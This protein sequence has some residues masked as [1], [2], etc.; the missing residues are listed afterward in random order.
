MAIQEIKTRISLDGESAYRAALKSIDQNMRILA[1]DTK[2]VA[3][4]FDKQKASMKNYN[5]LNAALSKQIQQQEI[6]VKSLGTA[7]KDC[8][9]KYNQ[10]KERAAAISKQFGD[11]SEQAQKAARGVKAAENA[12]MKYQAKLS[13]A[14]AELAKMNTQYRKNAEEIER[15]SQAQEQANRSNDNGVSSITNLTAAVRNG[16]IQFKLLTTA[17]SAVASAIKGISSVAIQ[18]VTK[19]VELSTKAF[20][21]YYKTALQAVQAISKATYETGSSFEAEMSKVQAYSGLDKMSSD[22]KALTNAASEAGKTTARTATEA[23]Q[24]LGYMA[25]AGYDAN[26]MLAGLNPL[27]L[28]SEAGLMDMKT[29]SDLV[30]DAMTAFGYSAD[31]MARFLDV[32]TA[33]QNNSNTSLQQLLEAMIPVSGMMDNL[34]VPIEEFATALGVLA[35]RGTK[36]SEAGH[37][38]LS[39]FTNLIGANKNAN[40]IMKEMGISVW[41]AEGNFIG[42]QE[43]LLL[44]DKTMQGMSVQETSLFEAKLGGKTQLDTLQ[45]LVAGV[46]NEWEELE[47]AV[48]DSNGALEKTA[49]TMYDNVAGSVTYLKSALDGLKEAA[50]SDLAEPMKEAIDDVTRYTQM[51]AQAYD[52]GGIEY[53]ANYFVNELKKNYVDGFLV[54]IVPEL[55]KAYETFQK[56]YDKVFLAVVDSAAKIMPNAVTRVINILRNSF[57]TVTQGLVPYVSTAVNAVSDVIFKLIPSVVSSFNTFISE[58]L[59]SIDFGTVFARIT[60]QIET[61]IPAMIQSGFNVINAFLSGINEIVQSGYLITIANTIITNLATNIMNSATMLINVASSLIDFLLNAIVNYAPAMI[62]GASQLITT[63]LNGITANVDKLTQA[64]VEIVVGLVEL[65]ADNVEPL[66]NC[67]VQLVSYLVQNLVTSENLNRIVNAAVEIIGGLVRG[68]VD[69]A[70]T[71]FKAI[72]SI[73][74]EAFEYIFSGDLINSIIQLI[75]DLTGSLAPLIVE[76]VIGF[77]DTIVNAI[78]GVIDGVVNL[79]GNGGSFLKDGFETLKNSFANG[80]NSLNETAE[81]FAK[82]FTDMFD[83]LGLETK[84]SIDISLTPNIEDTGEITNQ[85]SMAVNTAVT[86]LNTGELKPKFTLATDFDDLNKKVEKINEV[87]SRFQFFADNTTGDIT[88]I[89]NQNSVDNTTHLQKL[90]DR[91]ASIENLLNKANMQIEITNHLFPN[92]E[93]LGSTIHEINMMNN[94]VTGGY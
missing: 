20:E 11:N 22:F 37:K 70:P 30:T 74:H 48:T 26:E 89:L 49:T 93:T 65:I 75:T 14:Q 46:K 25:L 19:D 52:V 73:V 33:A 60:G 29:C 2:I 94:V 9:T 13:A 83:T 51:L 80:T 86:D 67:A 87:D 81:S 62:Q 18:T 6:K 8:T 84:Q 39:I 68:I 78:S 42:L 17:V 36:S 10:A 57:S 92:A 21:T 34:N 90:D 58:S 38:L 31:Q 59:N 55:T 63:L 71:L 85:L 3:N 27:V 66:I 41:D 7:V 35:N 12:M 56:S 28:A 15:L 16:N 24:A 4:S 72:S 45:K 1:N 5:D 61:N 77:V 76:L 82:S 47:K 44:L 50:F 40:S 88:N 23:A 53:A 32:A 54:T 91:L 43:S 79:M 69:S 64:A